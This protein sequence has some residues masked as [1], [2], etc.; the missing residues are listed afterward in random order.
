M[1]VDEFEGDLKGLEVNVCAV[2]SVGVNCW[3]GNGRTST[4]LY[5]REGRT[6]SGL[7]VVL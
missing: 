7:L 3:R 2:G 5:S 1:V 6:G 4:D